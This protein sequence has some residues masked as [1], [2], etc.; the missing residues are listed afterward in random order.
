[1][2]FVNPTPKLLSTSVFGLVLVVFLAAAL[3][4]CSGGPNRDPNVIL[5]EGGQG[6][7]LFAPDDA[8]QLRG[9]PKDF[10]QYMAHEVRSAVE[11]DDSSCSEP[12]VYS[13]TAI[14][15]D[16]HAAGE[17][18]RC[19]VERIFWVRKSGEWI[20]IWSGTGVPP[21]ADLKRN[22]IPSGLTKARCTADGRTQDYT[23]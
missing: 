22:D 9:A 7:P 1:M 18:S 15:D 16:G 23:G 17:L 14:A 3:S 6:Q 5:Y 12:P 21:C 20:K 19:G 2:P 8:R 4:G 10:Q 11:S 13:V